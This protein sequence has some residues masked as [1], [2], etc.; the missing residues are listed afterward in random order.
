LLLGAT[1]IYLLLAW[2]MRCDELSE[3]YGIAM[4]AEAPAASLA[5]LSQES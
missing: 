2:A 3:I 1:A 4:K 5:G